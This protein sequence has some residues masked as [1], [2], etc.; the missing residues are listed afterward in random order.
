[1]RKDWALGARAFCSLQSLGGCAGGDALS[2]EGV[3]LAVKEL[4]GVEPVWG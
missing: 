4:R 1:M 3:S 2:E